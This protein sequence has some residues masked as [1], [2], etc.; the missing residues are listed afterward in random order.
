MSKRAQSFQLWAPSELPAP[1]ITAPMVIT[2]T[3]SM[4]RVEIVVAAES[5]EV[6]ADLIAAFDGREWFDAG[7]SNCFAVF[8]LDITRA[9]SQS[10]EDALCDA[11]FHGPVLL[12]RSFVR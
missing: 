1:R 5:P 3:V 7:G 11:W 6:P 12:Y 4:T 2:R 10:E 9:L 8:G